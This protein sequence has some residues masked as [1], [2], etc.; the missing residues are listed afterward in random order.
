MRKRLKPGSARERRYEAKSGRGGRSVIDRARRR[1]TTRASGEN[2]TDGNAY[3]YFP[4]I[5]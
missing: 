1:D 5:N 2:A 4:K 3:C